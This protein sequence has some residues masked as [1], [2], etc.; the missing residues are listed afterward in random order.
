MGKRR[1]KVGRERKEC[2]V[3]EEAEGKRY[4]YGIELAFGVPFMALQLTNPTRT[5]EDAGSIPGLIQWV[6]DPALP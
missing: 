1:M 5:H 2:E 3:L 4:A 6:K